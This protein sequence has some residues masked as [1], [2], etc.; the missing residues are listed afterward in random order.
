MSSEMTV[1]GSK[2]CCISNAVDKTDNDMLWNGS[3]E[4]GDVRS[5]RKLKAVTVKMER[6]ALIGICR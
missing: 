4:N 1:K 5:I 6:A 2:T 3:E